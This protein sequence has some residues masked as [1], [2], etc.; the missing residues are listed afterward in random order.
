[1]QDFS[2]NDVR[3]RRTASTRCLVI[4]HGQTVGAVER[5][6][7]PSD[8]VDPAFSRYRI[9]LYDSANGPCFVHHR[10]QVRLA[11]AD[12]LWNDDIVP[13][14]MPPALASSAAQPALPH[15]R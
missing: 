8:P 4:V 1:M 13:T 11:I 2:I 9:E 10:S 14:P 6:A 12:W 15:I 5:I 7:D 3:F